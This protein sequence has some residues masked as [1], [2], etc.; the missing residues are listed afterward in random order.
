MT[1]LFA[2]LSCLLTV[3]TSE[4]K[5]PFLLIPSGTVISLKEQ[6][7]VMKSKFLF[8]RDGSFGIMERIHVVSTRVLKFF[9]E[10]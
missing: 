2:Y 6:A 5:S 4:S 8:D 1:F 7:C 3:L 10:I 9:V